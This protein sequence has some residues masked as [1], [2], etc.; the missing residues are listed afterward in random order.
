MAGSRDPALRVRALRA[1]REKGCRVYI[2][3]EQLRE[4]GFGPTELPWYRVRTY[5]RSRNAASAIVS[6]YREP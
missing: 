3:A 5:Q 2:S 1:G 6:L 4:A